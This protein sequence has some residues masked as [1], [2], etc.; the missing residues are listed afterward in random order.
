M[1]EDRAAAYFRRNF[2]I[3]SNRFMN[4]SF[5]KTTEPSSEESQFSIGPEAPVFYPASQEEV[6]A[7]NEKSVKV[8]IGIK[9]VG[10]A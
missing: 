1:V 4:G 10:V 6:L 5:L 8:A 7:L 2:S 9:R 3:N